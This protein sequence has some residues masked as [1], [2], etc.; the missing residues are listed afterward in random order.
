[1]YFVLR[2]NKKAS[3]EHRS[4]AKQHALLMFT[5]LSTVW[6]GGRHGLV[7]SHSS[8]CSIRVYPSCRCFKER[9]FVV[10]IT[11]PGNGIDCWRAAFHALSKKLVSA[12]TG[13]SLHQSV[14]RLAPQPSFSLL[15][16]MYCRVDLV[17]TEDDSLGRAHHK[18]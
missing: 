1:M 9:F 18:E 5:W 13:C 11:K 14:N 15:T 17:E 12:E 7:S 2:S 16:I 4:F 3:K 6:G 10:F 8:K